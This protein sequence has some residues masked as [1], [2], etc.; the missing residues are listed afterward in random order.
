MAQRYSCRRDLQ[1]AAGQEH[2]CYYRLRCPCA[3]LVIF[4]FRDPRATPAARFAFG[5]AFLR[6]ARFNFFRSSLSVTFFV[7]IRFFSVGRIFRQA[8]SGRSVGS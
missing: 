4:F 7:S 6:A 3:A 1:H 2:L 5:A 8:S